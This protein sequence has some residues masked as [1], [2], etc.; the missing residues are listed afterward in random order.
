MEA[1]QNEPSRKRVRNKD[2]K[3]QGAASGENP[4]THQASRKKI[5]VKRRM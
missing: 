5:K 4:E 3:M 2:D 1:A